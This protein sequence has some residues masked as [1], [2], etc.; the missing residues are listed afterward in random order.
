MLTAETIQAE[1]NDAAATRPDGTRGGIVT[2]PAGAFHL[3]RTLNI[4][5]GVVLRGQGQQATRLIAGKGVSPAVQLGPA[6][7]TAFGARLEKLAVLAENNPYGVIS[8]CAQEG[9]GLIDCTVRD[10]TTAGFAAL[11]PKAG[12]RSAMMVIDRCQFWGPDTGSR[13]GILFDGANNAEPSVIRETTILGYNTSVG[14]HQAGIEVRDSMVHVQDCYVEKTL[15]GILA[16]GPS[17]FLL[18]TNLAAA[19]GP[20]TEPGRGTIRLV[21]ESVRTSIRGITNYMGR[22]RLIRLDYA[23][24]DIG[25]DAFLA[26]YDHDRI[27]IK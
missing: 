17:C 15:D 10:Y 9:S 4:P 26:A 3:P 18:V 1:L 12:A 25:G 8:Y 23:R 24:K 19:N 16:S 21:H 11:P 6:A 2:L 14:H 13:A 20:G 27:T 5:S 7:G 22:A